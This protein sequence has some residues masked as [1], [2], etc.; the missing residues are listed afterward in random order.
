MAGA[1]WM[2]EEP[3]EVEAGAGAV[4]LPLQAFPSGLM[5]LAAGPLSTWRFTGVLRP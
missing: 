2:E 3:G 1:G 4:S 5:V